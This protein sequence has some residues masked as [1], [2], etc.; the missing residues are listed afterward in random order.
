M[1]SAEFE[2]AISV[3]EQLKNYL[4]DRTATGVGLRV[5]TRYNTSGLQTLYITAQVASILSPYSYV[6]KDIK[7]QKR[8]NV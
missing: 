6:A 4:F 8:S 1:S 2:P 3:T 5:V 7:F